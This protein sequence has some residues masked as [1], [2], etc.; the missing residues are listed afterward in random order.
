VS[1]L[2]S[3]LHAGGI[4]APEG[5]SLGEVLEATGFQKSSSPEEL[6]AELRRHHLCYYAAKKF[7]PE[8]GVAGLAG[9]LFNPAQAPQILLGLEKGFKAVAVNFLTWMPE[10][11]RLVILQ[12]HESAGTGDLPLNQPSRALML[13]RGKRPRMLSLDPS[14]YGL[15][16]LLRRDLSAWEQARAVESLLSGEADP[17]WNAERKLVLYNTAFRLWVFGGRTSFSEGLQEAGERLKSGKGLSRYLAWLRK[18]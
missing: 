2:P 12:S 13:R 16:G 17:Q 10:L 9:R 15:A 4:A 14:H 11:E 8:A 1:G 3:V 7:C 6:E 18:R 5:P